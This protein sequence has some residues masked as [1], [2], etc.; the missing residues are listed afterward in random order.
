[1]YN[2]SWL[3]FYWLHIFK[4]APNIMLSTSSFKDGLVTGGWQLPGYASGGLYF[5]ISGVRI[6]WALFDS[7]R[8]QEDPS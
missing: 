5:F 1:M 3:E 4:F 6:R 7:S 8:D 2:E